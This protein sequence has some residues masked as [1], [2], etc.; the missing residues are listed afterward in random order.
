M[1]DCALFAVKEL[2]ARH[3]ESLFYGQDVGG[4]L[5]G[6]FREA[7]TLAQ[8]FGDDRVFNSNRKL[9]INH[10]TERQGRRTPSVRY[11]SGRRGAGRGD[12]WSCYKLNYLGVSFRKPTTAHR[13]CTRNDGRHRRDFLE[14]GV[15]AGTDQVLTSS[16]LAPSLARPIPRMILR[17]HRNFRSH[18][19]AAVAATA[20]GVKSNI[21][22]KRT[23]N[24]A[25]FRRENAFDDDHQNV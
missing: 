6:V 22:P 25:G 21:T 20:V 13:S 12:G 1:V 3:P 23:S 10:D 7:A 5:G 15:S 11:M 16:L 8:M 17:G 4:R 24:K 9:P 14:S 2:L 19:P 18:L